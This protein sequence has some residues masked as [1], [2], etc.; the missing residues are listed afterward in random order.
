[1]EMDA[2]TQTVI[3]NGMECPYDPENHMALVLCE[4]CSE[5]NEVECWLSDDGEPEFAGFV[6]I[7][8]GHYNAPQ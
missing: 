4:N 8:C 7:K 1:M 2:F 3:I 6:C 5:T